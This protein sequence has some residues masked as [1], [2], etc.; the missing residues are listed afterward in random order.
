[1]RPCFQGVMHLRVIVVIVI[2]KCNYEYRNVTIKA[3][4]SR[5]IFL[6]PILSGHNIYFVYNLIKRYE[7]W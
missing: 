7:N 5:I 3:Y 4:V 2:I 6:A 1:M